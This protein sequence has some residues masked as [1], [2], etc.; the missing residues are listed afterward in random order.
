MSISVEHSHPISLSSEQLAQHGSQTQTNAVSSNSSLESVPLRIIFLDID[1]VICCNFDGRLE[2][3]RLAQL[4]RVVDATGAKV[5]LSSDW[6]RHPHLVEQVEST[7]LRMGVDC[8]GATPQG[9]LYR[10]IR[11]QEITQWLNQWN[12]LPIHDWVAMDDRDL[13]T[14]EGGDALQGR[15]VHTLFRSG[16]TAPLADMAIQILSQS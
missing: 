11:P 12:G 15:F 7:L 1:G 10:R 4:G 5:V 14:E 8:L 3:E 6:R 13:L 16:L 9:A 2:E